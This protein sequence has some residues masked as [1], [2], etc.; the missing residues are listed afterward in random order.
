MSGLRG[1]IPATV[2]IGL[3]IFTGY[4]TFHPAIQELNAE[5]RTINQSATTVANNNLTKETPIPT[6][7]QGNAPIEKSENSSESS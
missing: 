7:S 5:R 2:A 3:G 1:L 6:A 4:Y